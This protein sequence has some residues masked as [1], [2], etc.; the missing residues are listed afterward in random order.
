MELPCLPCVVSHGKKNS[1]QFW[2][3]DCGAF[4]VAPSL[5]VSLLE[6]RLG[7]GMLGSQVTGIAAMGVGGSRAVVVA[8]LPIVLGLAA[9]CIGPMGV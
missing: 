3:S 7:C 9:R 4:G 1:V 6:T 2:K 8:V 5:E